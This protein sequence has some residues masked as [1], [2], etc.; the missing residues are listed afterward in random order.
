MNLGEFSVFC[1]VRSELFTTDSVP[2]RPCQSS[3][4]V[5]LVDAAT[6]QSSGA[7]EG[8]PAGVIRSL[9]RMNLGEFSVFC[10]VRSELLRPTL[11]LLD[12]ASHLRMCFWWTRQHTRALE[13]TRAGRGNKEPCKDDEP[14]IVFCIL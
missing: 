14:W 13:T 7:N 1:K 6:H 8:W 3:E 11:R 4:N 2:P 10:K 5:F 12:P 9:V